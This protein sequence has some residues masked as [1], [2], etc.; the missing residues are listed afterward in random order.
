MIEPR[1]VCVGDVYGTVVASFSGKL[2]F[3]LGGAQAVVLPN[4]ARPSCGLW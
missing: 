4:C 1:G 3:G 2:W